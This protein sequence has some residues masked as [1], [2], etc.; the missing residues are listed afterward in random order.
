MKTN[1]LIEISFFGHKCCE[2]FDIVDQHIRA[3][4]QR[5][6]DV[7]IETSQRI[8]LLVVYASIL[9]VFSDVL[10]E[11]VDEINL[12]F[13]ASKAIRVLVHFLFEPLYKHKTFVSTT[14]LHFKCV[15]QMVGKNSKQ[16]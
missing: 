2:C 16:G 7:I 11:I 6:N 10:F 15:M 14:L 13:S 12:L 5:S 8:V 1:D 4:F 3:C 9:D